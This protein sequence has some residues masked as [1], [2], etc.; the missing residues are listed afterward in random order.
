MFN[1]YQIQSNNLII[2]HSPFAFQFFLVKDEEEE[3]DLKFHVESDDY[4]VTLAASLSLMRQI[5]LKKTNELGVIQKKYE[6]MLEK[7][8]RDLVFLNKDYKIIKK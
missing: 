4:F 3:R 2:T 5:V 7:I 1:Q 6:K 8:E